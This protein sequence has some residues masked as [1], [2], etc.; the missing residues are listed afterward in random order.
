MPSPCIITYNNKKYPYEEFA[1][2]LHDGHL[3]EL[4]SNGTIDASNFIGAKPEAQK[5]GK[6]KTEENA[7]TEREIKQG[8]ITEYQNRDESRKASETSDS[9]R[10]VEG[11]K[12]QKEEVVFKG[13]PN[14][15]K[16]DSEIESSF[17]KDLTENYEERKAEYIEKNGNVFDTDRARELSSDYRANPSEKSNAVHIPAR[18][19]VTKVYKEELAKDAPKGKEN[20]VT[21]TAGSS[22]V[23]KSALISD[24]EKSKSQLIVDTNMRNYESSKAD[25]EE[26][27]AAGKKVR[28]RFMYRN[29]VQA[30]VEGVMGGKHR[31][32]RTVPYKLTTDI[33]KESLETIIKLSKDFKGNPDVDIKYFN[34][35]GKKG[36]LK[37]FSLSDV[38][39]IKVDYNQARKEIRDEIERQYRNGEIDE[40]Q[41]R[42]FS[43]EQKLPEKGNV[44]GGVQETKRGGGQDVNRAVQGTETT[45]Q[46]VGGNE[47]ENERGGR[48]RDE[49]IDEEEQLEAL[50]EDDAESVSKLNTDIEILKKFTDKDIAS[51]KF[52]A[53]I[54]KAFKMKEEG[55]ISK[56]TYTKYR[57][58]AQQVL[59]PKVNID[60]EKAKFHIE[61][62]KEEVKKK[63]LGENYKKILLS[64]PGF[65]PKQVEH[66]I[67]LTAKAAQKLIDAGYSIKEAV[68]K[69]LSHIKEHPDYPKL[70]EE[71]HLNEK[72]FTKTVNETFGQIEEEIKKEEPKQE[73]KKKEEPK[74]EE[75]KKEKAT[76]VTSK[77]RKHTSRILES[78]F[79]D[80]EIKAD[81]AEQGYDYIP[82]KI[83]MAQ[84]DARKI[85]Q[86]FD[87][88]GQ[89]DKLIDKIKTDP[90][91]S[92]M[93]KNSIA[94]TIFE[95]LNK[96]ASREND[97]EAKTDLRKKA[98]DV[99]QFLAK[100]LTESAQDLRINGA[101]N[102]SIANGDPEVA[103][104]LLKEQAQEKINEKLSDRKT[105]K[106]IAESVNSINDIEAEIE[107]RTKERISEE[108]EKEIDTRILKV[109][110]KE[111]LDKINK[112]LDSLMIKAN[113]K[114]F[115]DV[116]GLGGITTLVWN[117]SLN[118]VK[119]SIKIGILAYNGIANSKVIN[120]AIQAGIDY[121]KENGNPDFN[122]EEYRTRVREDVVNGLKE[123][124]IEVRDKKSRKKEISDIVDEAISEIKEGK[125]NKDKK[126]NVNENKQ[127]D[128]E[129][130]KRIIS[131][132]IDKLELSDF[133]KKKLAESVIDHLENNNGK[134]TKKDFKNLYG[135]AL[136]YDFVTPEIEKD[137]QDNFEEIHKAEDL[138][139]KINSKLDEAVKKE[140]EYKS[141]GKDMPSIERS[142][143]ISEI[144]DL[145]KQHNQQVLKAQ[146]ANDKISDHFREGKSF[147]RMLGG[148]LQGNLLTPLSQIVN[149]V[150]YAP[151]LSTR[152]LTGLGGTALDF[153]ESSLAKTGL[154]GDKLDKNLKTNTFAEL[155]YGLKYGAVPGLKESLFKLRTGQ[156]SEDA[157][158]RDAGQ[159]FNAFESLA[160]F[161]KGKG[162]DFETKLTNFV[163]G[164]FGVPADIMFRL[165]GPADIMVRKSKEYGKLAEIAKA[166]GL[167]G[168][169]LMRDILNPPSESK[170]IAQQESLKASYQNDNAVT[171]AIS[172][173]E[174]EG[175]E[176]MK[177][178]AGEKMAYHI[179]GT[180]GLMK[181]G[182]I[183]FTKTPLNIIN[184]LIQYTCP[185]IPFS[186]AMIALKHGDRR[187]FNIGM[188]KAA[189]G[190]GFAYIASQVVANGLMTGGPDEEE[191]D[192]EKR[193]MYENVGYK[194]LNWS[195]MQRLMNGDSDWGKI[196]NNDTWVNYEKMGLPGMIFGTWANYFKDKTKEE[197]KDQNPMINFFAGMPASLKASIE[198]S[199]LQGTNKALEAIMNPEGKKAKYFMVGYIGSL[200]SIAYPNTLATISKSSDALIRDKRT[201]EGFMKMLENDFKPKLFM[202]DKLPS[203]VTLWGEDA[204]SVPSGTNPYVYYL[205]DPIKAKDIPTQNFGY[206]IFDFWRS[207][208]SS[209]ADEKAK[210][211]PS[212]PKSSLTIKGQEI[213]LTPNEYNQFQK[214]VGKSRAEEAAQYVLYGD[215]DT[216]N[217]GVRIEKLQQI[218]KN[219]Y[220]TAKDLFID[221]NDR[222]R[223][224]ENE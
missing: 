48:R 180:V 28:I 43:G 19:F 52:K 121:I 116:T 60:A 197:I 67:D 134:I 199:F 37:P 32:G 190:A 217:Q 83:N 193:A 177:K 211:L 142:S 126:E 183:P 105:E 184:E 185:V 195:A 29:P 23:G 168:F 224:I 1:Q 194:K 156:L 94:A 158:I 109:I 182:I 55:K 102:K 132:S 111:S 62:L 143:Y 214:L 118:A 66:L 54:E 24:A 191:K 20:V 212:I 140:R 75:P 4:I 131:E 77:Q 219:G 141:A 166:K 34:N 95:H 47:K 222:L 26:A 30:F 96:K 169:E 167:E 164:H 135:E 155:K 41:Y 110:S 189:V 179:N 175:S 92:R 157:T 174:K 8:D 151:T 87:E 40:K 107:K 187:E 153:A 9:D 124:G 18:D 173:L 186:K 81:L 63:L 112:F 6:L 127:K 13:N 115:S 3:D 192:K 14:L 98:I 38:K 44:T 114:L 49:L 202:G 90:D 31:G 71:G 205:L 170:E 122:E 120:S 138:Q 69:A 221:Q 215:F 82:R 39:K 210:V 209:N 10:N 106:K 163:E 93:E 152:F 160:N 56:P 172:Y 36:E 64:A 129:K 123:A 80:P 223:N 148:L 89:I 97:P 104:T 198:G 57:N 133:A 216:D 35:T 5:E 103:I 12:K 128:I 200:A 220:T 119:A 59:G 61:Q 79:V 146:K 22:G 50:K 149:I 125:K 196:K 25:I 101:I 21:F 70:I 51:K 117:G 76:E 85:V 108:I 7:V 204:K 206:K 136:G 161:Y 17:Q 84:S 130:A 91:M 137:I 144:N 27:L 154:F 139:D 181:T 58:I 73:E 88:G 74:I 86:Y 171:K 176:W 65:G 45:G 207:I 178:I 53:I 46:G 42:G 162:K 16:E 33:H 68:S 201:D 2:M 113:G 165:L 72:D 147:Y 188:S 159:K 213:P 78:E 150:S 15:S 218:Y 145:R 99:H 100:N 11:G 203:R 208:P